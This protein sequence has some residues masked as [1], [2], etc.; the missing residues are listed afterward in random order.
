MRS[1]CVPEESYL[2]HNVSSYAF[3]S[4]TETLDRAIGDLD[5]AKWLLFASAFIAIVISFIYIKFI[6]YLGRCLVILSIIGTFVGGVFVGLWL[7][8]DGSNNMD[9]DET[10]NTGRA[11]IALGVIVFVLLFCFFLALF[12]MRSVCFYPFLLIELAF[13]M[14]NEASRAVRDMPTTVLFPVLY[15]FVGIAYMAFWLSV[16]LYIYS[17]KQRDTYNTPEDLVKYFGD[18]YIHVNF[19][20]E[21]KVTISCGVFDALVYHFICL[22]YMIQVIVYFGFMVLAGTFAD[23]Y[24]SI[25]DS[26]HTRK[27]RGHSTA[28]LS[29]API[30][31]SLF[32]VIRFHIGSLA[33][34]ALLITPVRVVRWTLLYIQKKTQNA[35]NP[36]T[37]CLLGCAD[38]FLKC[39]EC[40]IDKIN[41]EGFIFTT[42]YGTNFCYSS[43]IAIKLIWNN[44][45]RAALVEGISHYMELFG[46]LAIAS[47]T[48]GLCL[49]IF[50]EAS[51]YRDNLS[52]V[53]LPGLVV[54][55]VSYMI[56]SLFMLVYEVAVDT[57]FLCYLVDEE[58]HPEG[59]KFAH[60]ELTK[61]T[62]IRKHSV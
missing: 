21:L 43:I 5:T 49:A 50:S 14:L 34:G 4:N 33:F 44:A 40:I 22:V 31:E 32:R 10:K 56:G 48:T 7:I 20:K 57:I 13:S 11:E 38:C 12:W 18:T 53:L 59:P 1:W 45:M 15:S 35:Q 30:I 16:A 46:R 62:S 36:L 2:S 9:S 47:L 24:F 52:S 29:H 54:F 23:W 51:Y 25:W 26:T 19:N 39:F 58:T 3:N 8:K 28:E 60:A 17:S 27:I 55:I 61:M 6:S 41:K 37:K 42:I